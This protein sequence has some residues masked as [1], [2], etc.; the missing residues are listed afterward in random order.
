MQTRVIQKTGLA[1]LTAAAL[2]GAAQVMLFPS[3]V[4]RLSLIHI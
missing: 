3:N 2:F 4:G 1:L